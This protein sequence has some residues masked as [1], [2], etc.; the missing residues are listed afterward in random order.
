M[1]TL[2]SD[3]QTWYAAQ[4]DE[5]W[6]HCYGIKITTMDNPGWSLTAEL[7]ETL[8]ADKE[9]VAFE[10]KDS[11]GKWIEC[12]VEDNKFIGY[13][14]A[15]QLEDLISTFLTWAKT[16]PDWLAKEYETDEEVKARLD[17]ELWD[18]LGEENGFSECRKEG[19]S[20]KH[21]TYSAFCRRHHFEMVRGYGPPEFLTP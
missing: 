16:E 21:I 8:L 4:C 1:Q 11:E 18:A 15:H 2:L 10:R 20:H 17:Q 3:L 14:G 19:C 7:Q 12:H 9:F 13:A 6:E 5:E